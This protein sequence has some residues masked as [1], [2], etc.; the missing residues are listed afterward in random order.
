M[1]KAVRILGLLIATM[2]I[3]SSCKKDEPTPEPTLQEKIK[4]KWIGVE[5][6]YEE[7]VPGEPLHTE[8]ED[9][10]WTN[11]DFRANGELV[12]DSAGFDPYTYQYALTSDG[13]FVWYYDPVNSEVHE[14]SVLTQNQLHLDVRGT[15][16]NTDGKLV[17]YLESLRMRR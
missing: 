16:F 11:F 15:Y 14:I 8:S 13:K 7:Q 9:I 5:S 6:Y 10:S 3:I 2:L 4:G 12:I 1:K 17:S